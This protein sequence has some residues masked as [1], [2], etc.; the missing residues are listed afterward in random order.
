LFVDI[1]KD[2]PLTYRC[3]FFFLF[4]LSHSSVYWRFSHTSSM[5]NQLDKYA[6]A[7]DSSIAVTTSHPN[8]H[9]IP[10]VA[11]NDRHL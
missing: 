1:R 6:I 2:K 10:S 4:I 3:A 7:K 5:P 11:Q 8:H 9:N